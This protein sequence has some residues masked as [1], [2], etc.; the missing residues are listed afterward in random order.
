MGLT[1][2]DHFLRSVDAE[3]LDLSANILAR[4]EPQIA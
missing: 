2:N 1:I 4:L 3:R